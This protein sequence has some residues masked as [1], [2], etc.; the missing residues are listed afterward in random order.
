MAA[1]LETQ[2]PDLD[3]ESG[4]CGWGFYKTSTDEFLNKH[5]DLRSLTIENQKLFGDAIVIGRSK[6]LDFGEEYSCLN[7][8]FFEIFFN[9]YLLSEKGEPPLEFSDWSI[10][11]PCN[12]KTGP[13]W[14]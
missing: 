6:L 9:M 7:V 1:W 2:I 3:D 8:D 4:E 5:L 10:I 13:G 12:E 14:D 11:K